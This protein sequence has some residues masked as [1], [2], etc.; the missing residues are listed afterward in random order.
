[1]NIS[2][3]LAA[4]VVLTLAGCTLYHAAPLDTGPTWPKDISRL[5]VDAHSLPFPELASHV[6][7]SRDGLDMTE[8]AM[9]AVVNNPDLSLARADLGLAQAQAFDAGLLPDPQFS[10]SP[11]IPETGTPGENVIAFD[12]GL[13]YDLSALM[14]HHSRQAA[15]NAEVRKADLALLWQEWQVVGEA[16]LLFVRLRAEHLMQDELEQQQQLAQRLCEADRRAL[17]QGNSTTVNLALDE[18]NLADIQHQLGDNQLLLSQN[19]AALNRLLGLPP[20]TR[21]VLVG[22]DHLVVPEAAQ[23][24]AELPTLAQRR[25]DLLAMQAGYDAEDQRLWQAILGQFPAI[26]AGLLKA[27][28]NNGTNYHGY[29]VSLNLPIFNRNRGAIAIETA[30][31]QRMHEEYQQRLQTAWQ[32]ISQILTDLDIQNN[33]LQQVRDNLVGQDRLLGQA[34][35]AFQAGNMDLPTWISLQQARLTRALQETALEG[36]LQEER[37]ALLTLSGSEFDT[38]KRP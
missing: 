31:R 11:Q 20:M 30:T 24:N 25:P 12:V 2:G 17:E 23:V 4:G 8:V 14:L 28:D 33:T 10:Y 37:V 15:A 9:L 3:W 5:T 6:F 29:A 7:D 13:N 27:R 18:G 32:E 16:R 35:L 38:G 34:G 19:T 22:D 26:N 21:L 1:M 36:A